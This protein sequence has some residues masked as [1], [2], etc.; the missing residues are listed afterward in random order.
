[1]LSLYNRFD[2]SRVVTSKNKTELTLSF[3]KVA[4]K[5]GNSLQL[6]MNSGGS[7]GIDDDVYAFAADENTVCYIKYRDYFNGS[8]WVNCLFINSSLQK[9]RGIIDDNGYFYFIKDGVLLLLNSNG[10]FQ[11]VC[12]S[13]TITSFAEDDILCSP[14]TVSRITRYISALKSDN[15]DSRV[16]PEM[17]KLHR[18]VD[19]ISNDDSM[20]NI[21]KSVLSEIVISTFKIADK[22]GV[23]IQPEIIKQLKNNL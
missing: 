17:I 2:S 10:L 4:F 1:M 6:D 5:D 18:L 14:L 20:K 11:P 9:V 3:G 22:A 19:S 21:S 16:F 15:N 8:P 7:C 12:K 13:S 23:N